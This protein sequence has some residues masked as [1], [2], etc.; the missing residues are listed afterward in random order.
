MAPVFTFPSISLK[1]ACVL[2]V[3]HHQEYLIHRFTALRMKSKRFFIGLVT[4]K[5]SCLEWE[6][7][8]VL[9]SAVYASAD[10]FAT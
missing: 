4:A 2:S 7:L 5:N 6:P 10:W 8:K 3:C 9:R 1:V